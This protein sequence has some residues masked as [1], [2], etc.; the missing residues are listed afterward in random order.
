MTHTKLY[1]PDYTAAEIEEM[2]KLIDAGRYAAYHAYNWFQRGRDW[3]RHAHNIVAGYGR[4][5]AYVRAYLHSYFEG[6][7]TE[8][9]RMEISAK[10]ARKIRNRES[11]LGI[12]RKF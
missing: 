7:L 11:E 4:D 9:Q 1:L 8:S 10:I 2:R 6:K 5:A 12:K 3:S